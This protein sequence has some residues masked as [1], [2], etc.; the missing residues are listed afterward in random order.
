VRHVSVIEAPSVLGLFPGGVE[1][2]PDA[3]RVAG[4]L[5]RLRAERMRVDAPPF[6]AGRH[7]V[8]LLNNSEA[9]AAY[10]VDLA[11]AIGSVLDAGRFPLVVGGDCS[12]GFGSYL[13]LVRRG[14]YGVLFLDGHADFAHPGEADEGDEPSGE[15][16]SMDLAIATGRGPDGFVVGGVHPLL[17]EHDVAVLAYRVHTDGT[18]TCRGVHIDDTAI[19]AIDLAECRRRGFDRA[20]ADALAVVTRPELDGCWIH[21]DA[22]V[23]HDDVMPAVDYRNPDGVTWDELTAIVAAAMATGRVVGM[24]LTIF[25]P[26]LDRDGSITARM[27][28]FL[29]GALSS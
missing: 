12:I 7:P 18:D 6:V 15:A 2:M 11:A 22:D 5:D 27:V 26:T 19:T 8:T 10:A 14:R 29:A 1:T 24:H 4:L 9:M 23:L 21:L 17:R 13:A 28:D 16:A 20:I 25:N 3:L